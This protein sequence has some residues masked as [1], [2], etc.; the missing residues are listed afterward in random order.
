MNERTLINLITAAAAAASRLP[1]ALLL[2]LWL[3]L[4]VARVCRDVHRRVDSSI[5]FADKTQPERRPRRTATRGREGA[6]SEEGEGGG[7]RRQWVVETCLTRSK[8]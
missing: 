3:W 8:T 6:R 2:R 7:A 4:S 5:T 1:S